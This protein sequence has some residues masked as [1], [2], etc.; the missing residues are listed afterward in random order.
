MHKKLI[1]VLLLLLLAVAGAGFYFLRIVPQQN[2]LAVYVPTHDLQVYTPIKSGD[3][4][5]RYVP[6]TLQTAEYAVTP[7]ELIG[8]VAIT[9]VPAGSVIPRMWLEKSDIL[10]ELRAV[11]VYSNFVRSNGARPG[12]TVD[13]YKVMYNIAGNPDGIGYEKVVSG[14]KVLLVTDEVGT[15]AY[16]QAKALDSLTTAAVVQPK[17]VTV[18]VKSADVERLLLGSVDKDNKYVLARWTGA[19][20]EVKAPA[21]PV[22]TPQPEPTVL[23]VPEEQPAADAS[24]QSAPVQ[25]GGFN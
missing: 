24:K 18:L 9:P 15:P 19:G 22:V 7:E 20:S 25:N 2:M 16:S 4:E 8:K 10:K 11:T 14:V 12:D 1:V 5:L 3:I 13:I 17:A 21:A 6:Q 23:P